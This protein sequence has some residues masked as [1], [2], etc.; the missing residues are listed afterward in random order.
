VF[1]HDGKVIAKGRNNTNE[2]KNATR[3]AEIEAMDSV[4]LG[5]N[6]LSLSIMQETSLYVTVEPCL[7]CAAAI[8]IMKIK[9]VYYGCGNDKFGGCG[10]IFAVHEG[11]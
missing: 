8:G 11:L 3:H 6:P 1:V 4:F 5:E 10:S 7:M 2:S 9:K